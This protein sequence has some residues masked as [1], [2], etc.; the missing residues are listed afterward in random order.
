MVPIL[1]KG[2]SIDTMNVTNIEAISITDAWYQVLYNLVV[3]SENNESGVRQ[4]QIS[5]GSF[6]GGRRLE[7]EMLIINISKPW[8]RPFIPEIPEGLGLPQVAD[9]D[10]IDKYMPY[11]ASPERQPNEHYTYGERLMISWDYVIN[12][13]R[14]YGWDT[15]RMIMEVGRPEDVFM[16]ED[17]DGSTPCL[18]LIQPR[19]YDGKMNWVVFFRSWDVYSALPVNLGGIQQMKEVMVDEIGNGLEDGSLC[20]ISPGAH[21]YDFQGEVAKIRLYREHNIFG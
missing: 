10:A 9:V 14:K 5:K 7:Y 19:I 15:N 4:Y 16:Y 8:I 20:V 21:I 6:E 1:V 12:Y 3:K 13:Y 18:R 17:R 2:T 11:L